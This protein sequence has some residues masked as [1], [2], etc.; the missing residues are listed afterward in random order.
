[1]EGFVRLL[2]GKLESMPTGSLAIIDLD[3]PDWESLGKG[4]ESLR[5][6][7]RPKEEIRTFRKGN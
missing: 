1:M 6:I 2:T 5:K 3:I 7:I 4:S